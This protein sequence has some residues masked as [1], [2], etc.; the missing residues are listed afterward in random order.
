VR[1]SNGPVS[2]AAKLVLQDMYRRWARIARERV[3]AVIARWDRA[4]GKGG[5]SNADFYFLLKHYEE[6]A[7][8]YENEVAAIDADI[9]ATLDGVSP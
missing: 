2:L 7:R 1:G 8:F 5:W 6:K 4:G 9:L 3:A